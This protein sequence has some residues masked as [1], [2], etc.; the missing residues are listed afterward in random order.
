MIYVFAGHTP[1]KDSGAVSGQWVE[2]NLTKELRD[3]VTTELKALGATFQVDDDGMLL[4]EV[5]ASIHTS[6]RDVIL[7]IHFNAGSPAATGTEVV[8]PV[9]AGA[10]EKANAA[11]LLA[12]INKASGIPSRGV[13]DETQTARKRLG[14]M[15]PNGLNMLVEVCFIT[16]TKD[17]ELYQSHKAAI[18][19]AIAELLVNA[20]SQIQ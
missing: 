11:A 8:I 16:N 6:E 12:L 5:I 14:I 7:D 2:A 9:N 15:R 1:G 13:I 18:A 17:M 10:H 19:K 4:K 3:L 20:Q